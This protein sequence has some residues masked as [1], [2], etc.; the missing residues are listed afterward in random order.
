MSTPLV[1]VPVRD[2]DQAR[3]DVVLSYLEDV[4]EL[5]F[6]LKCL[7]EFRKIHEGLLRVCIGTKRV[8]KLPERQL[9]PAPLKQEARDQLKH[10]E[11]EAYEASRR[12]L[13]ARLAEADKI[14]P[15]LVEGF[16]TGM[17]VPQEVAALMTKRLRREITGFV[18]LIGPRDKYFTLIPERDEPIKGLFAA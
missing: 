15:S 13:R 12:E 6:D 8:I 5:A 9:M 4:I 7:E 3:E 1:V 11:R 17:G 16:F 10:D 18:A 14:R 2:R